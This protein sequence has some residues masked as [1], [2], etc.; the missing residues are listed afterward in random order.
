MFARVY[1]P[2][3]VAAGGAYDMFVR[4]L[5][6][7]YLMSN[8]AFDRGPESFVGCASAVRRYTENGVGIRVR[9]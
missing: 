4:R 7:D 5:S 3:T 8:L 2:L 9:I 6:A 1:H